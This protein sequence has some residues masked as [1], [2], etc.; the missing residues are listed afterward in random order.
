[1]KAGLCPNYLLTSVIHFWERK[2]KRNSITQSQK[3]SQ[4]KTKA[5]S[6]PLSRLSCSILI[7][8]V[9][10]I[11][12]PQSNFRMRRDNGKRCRREHLWQMWPIL[13]KRSC[14]C[15]KVLIFFHLVLQQVFS[16][17]LLVLWYF[18]KTFA[19][20][21]KYYIY[22]TCKFAFSGLQWHSLFG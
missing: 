9:L 7:I 20:P 15:Y 2:R 5:S 1:M 21:V 11:L 19:S 10:L 14:S 6:C 22:V 8:L 12:M 16:L 18:K 13:Q 17:S 4:E 3:V